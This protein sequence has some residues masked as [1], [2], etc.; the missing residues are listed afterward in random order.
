MIES[1]KKLVTIRQDIAH[2][3][4]EIVELKLEQSDLWSKIRREFNENKARFRKMDGLSGLIQCLENVDGDYMLVQFDKNSN[5]S[6][7][8]LSLIEEDTGLKFNSNTD[9]NLY[10]FTL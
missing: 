6:A 8:A 3:Q 2:K 5:P 7:R 10:K 9:D 1:S 4:K